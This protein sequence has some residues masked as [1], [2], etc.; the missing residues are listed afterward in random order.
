MSFAYTLH[1]HTHTYTHTNI[2]IYTFLFSKKLWFL[3]MGNGSESINIYN[4]P[5]TMFFSNIG[6]FKFF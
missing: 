6:V 1:T 3:F 5:E 2:C 4:M